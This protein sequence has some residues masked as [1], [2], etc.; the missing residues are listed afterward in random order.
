MQ[1]KGGPRDGAGGGER[2]PGLGQRVPRSPSGS[3]VALLMRAH[4][5]EVPRT[6]LSGKWSRAKQILGGQRTFK[7]QG[8]NG[9]ISDSIIATDQ[10]IWG[11]GSQPRTPKFIPR[12]NLLCL[13]L[14]CCDLSEEDYYFLGTFSKGIL[15]RGI[16]QTGEPQRVIQVQGS[17]AVV[18][19]SLEP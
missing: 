17:E 7:I 11:Q 4:V 6:L 9:D 15:P 10:S 1:R 12:R 5:E 14:L 16:Y 2:A 19:R 8:Q 3:W 13:V 18:P